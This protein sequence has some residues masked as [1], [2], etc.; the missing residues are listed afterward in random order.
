M[1]STLSNLNFIIGFLLFFVFLKEIYS[2]G[3]DF[4][5][6]SHCHSCASRNP[7]S[8]GTGLAL[9]EI[10]DECHSCVSRNP[11]YAEIDSRFRGNDGECSDSECHSCASRNPEIVGTRLA[12][13]ESYVQCHSCVSRNPEIVG[14]GL[15][16]S[17]N[18]G[19]EIDS[20]FRGNDSKS[21]DAECHSCA[22]RNLKSVGTG[23][24]LFVIDAEIDFRF[25]GNDC[26]SDDAEC[27]SCASRNPEIV[28]SYVQCHSCAS[29]N[30]EIVGTRLALSANDDAEIDSRFRGNDGECSDSECHSC[31][32]RNPLYAEIDSRFRG[33]DGECSDA[34]CHSC[35]SRNPINKNISNSQP[36]KPDTIIPIN[37]K[38]YSTNNS[39]NIDNFTLNRS[40]F[41]S[42]IHLINYESNSFLTDLGLPSNFYELSFFQSDNRSNAFL[43]NERQINEPLTNIIDLRDL[44]FDEF[45]AIDFVFPTRSF[46]F[47][48]YNNQNAIIF[49]EW[50]R[51]SSIPLSRIRYIEG[52][53]DNLFFDGL[54][55]VNLTQKFNF[56]FGVTKHNALGRFLN[57][58]KDLWAG[59]V[60]LTHYLNN[61][62]NFDFI[63]RYSKSLV[64]FNEGININNPFLAQGE[65]IENVLYD[66][67]RALVINDDAYH[68]WTIHSIDINGILDL[69]EISQTKLNIYYQQSLR[70]YRDN[71]HKADSIRVFDNHWSKV[72]GIS[73]K[74]NLK[75]LFNQLELKGTYE[76]IIIESPFFFNKVIDDYFSFYAFNQIDLVNFLKPSIYFKINQIKGTNKN[77][78]SYGSDLQFNFSDKWNLIFGVSRFQKIFSYDERY[79]YNFSLNDFASEVFL[80]YGR[81]T[82]AF[83]K[84]KFSTEAYYRNESNPVTQSSFYS[85]E[86]G[87][88]ILNYPF[89]KVSAYGF[90]S[91][92]SFSFWKLNS[93]LAFSFNDNFVR[94]NQTNYHKSIY[95]R[96]QGQFELFYNDKLFKSSLDLLTGFRIKFFS[97]FAGRN[98]SSSKLSFVDVRTYN[99]SLINFGTITIPSNFT[100]DLVASGRVK[101][102]AIV[103][104]SIENLLDR[105]FYLMPYYPTN[106]IQFRFGI[107]WEFYD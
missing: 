87:N 73:L 63:Y 104:L 21:D 52:Q 79:F 82:F 17:A 93:R 105:K 106:D 43:I 23:L 26:K 35:A 72:L 80:L 2:V 61:Q 78:L 47:S 81:L 70:E 31:A 84:I 22:S 56:E 95:P 71:E 83:S 59:K 3:I 102:S 60:K 53:Y 58:E 86:Q 41:F 42:P 98:F 28:E 19:S 20:R 10:Y 29:R 94:L 49:R 18:D 57:S 36:S 25:C 44:R 99:D 107:A 55:N 38:S 75:L 40:N 13:S 65:P 6:T 4:Y 50:K 8:V 89:Q 91:D 46:L 77:F 76:R 15:A 45:E 67:Q 33:N 51:Y 32:S 16:L 34:E 30:P 85:I 54:F 48:R 69:N 64:R 74:E 9:S 27:H 37:Q 39:K 62:I 66:N 14:T 11:L 1:K 88:S 7:K 12:L 96:F 92:L 24:A 100:I 90:K 68:K 97:S 101:E 103:Y 5:F